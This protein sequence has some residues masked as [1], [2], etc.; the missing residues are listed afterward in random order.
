MLT[1]T[2]TLVIED[3]ALQL[4]FVRAQGPGGQNVNKV[5]TAVQLTL[6]LARCADLTPAVTERLARLAGRR[7]TGDG[8][9][10]IVAQR[11]RSQEQNRADALQRLVALLRR[12]VT[13][14]RPRR[15]TRPTRASRE[16]R[17]GAKHRRSLIKD[18][19]RLR[20]QEES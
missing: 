2:D 16:R 10:I 6:D 12:A 9:L 7:M 17:L 18:R 20:P 3:E 15:P 1:V 8:R 14:P 19:R 5:A 11:F 13:P 4:E